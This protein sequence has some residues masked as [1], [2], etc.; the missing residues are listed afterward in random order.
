MTAAHGCF[1]VTFRSGEGPAR[2]GILRT[3]HGEVQ[4]P[5]FMPVGTRAAVRTVTPDELEA[6]GVEMV[7]ANTY[8]LLL[9]PGPQLIRQAGGL[10]RFMGW[11]RPILTDSGGF[12]VFSLAPLRRVSDEGVL[13]RSHVDGSLQMLTPERAIETQWALGSDVSMVLDE[14][15]GYPAERTE[16]EAAVRRTAKWAGACVEAFRRC[17]AE[18]GAG[19]LLFGINQGGV[20]PDLR[21][22][23]LEQL[24]ELPFDGLAIGGLS[25]GEPAALMYEVLEHLQ[26][27][28]PEDRPRYVMGLGSPDV[29]VEAVARGYDM[30]DS[31]LPTRMARHGAVWTA[32]GRLNLRDAASRDRHEPIEEGCDCYACR[33]F[34]RAYVRH[35]L[36]AGEVLGMRLATLHNLRFMMR[37]MERIR[38]AVREGRLGALRQEVDELFV[39][40]RKGADDL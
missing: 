8:H 37:L 28:L 6:A 34:T 31:V 10:H 12:Q 27:L 9:R 18:G 36:K 38:A 23:S 4:T 30:F 26:P 25:V 22:A 20:F 32:R 35:L 11:S 40:R 3:P 7:L 16:V 15:V 39:R 17:Q 5:V 33:R 14:C 1:Q 19:R 21:R 2:L 29:L 24:L 13:F